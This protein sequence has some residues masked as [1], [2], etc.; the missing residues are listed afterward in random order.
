MGYYPNEDAAAFFCGEVLPRIRATA[1][2][3]IRTLIVGPHPTPRVLWLMQHADISVTASV[4]DIAAAYREADAVVVPVRAG[5]GSRIK[6]LE[7]FSYG[8]PV[9]STQVGAE[10]VAV[11]D[12]AELLIA[13]APGDFAAQCVRL[14]ASA[15]LRRALA[16]RALAFVTKHHS[17]ARILA[18]LRADHGLSGTRTSPTR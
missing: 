15:A 3:A 13:D 10:G 17:P 11:R 7:A 12:A 1:S 6:L 2:R 4:P 9:V 18:L 8:R 14:M 5:G 16:R